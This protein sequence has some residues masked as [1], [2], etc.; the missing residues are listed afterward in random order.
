MDATAVVRIGLASRAEE[1]TPGKLIFVLRDG[2]GEG[3]EGGEGSYELTSLAHL[4]KRAYPL[5]AR[6]PP[7]IRLPPN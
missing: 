2:T 3:K 1:Q 7:L 5:V 4:Y 6:R